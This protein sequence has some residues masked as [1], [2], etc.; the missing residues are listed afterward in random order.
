MGN[1]KWRGQGSRD[2]EMEG[3]LDS[4][5][6]LFRYI[7]VIRGRGNDGQRPM[8][9]TMLRAAYNSCLSCTMFCIEQLITCCRLHQP[10]TGQGRV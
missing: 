3:L 10:C 7:Q 5:L 2:D 8:A 9:H 4:V 1:G 6:V